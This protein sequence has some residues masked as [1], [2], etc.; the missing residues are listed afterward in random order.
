MD[1]VRI[2][3]APGIDLADMTD[4]SKEGDCYGDARP[5]DLRVFW[6]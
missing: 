1:A 2:I 5:D 4:T 3:D 6:G